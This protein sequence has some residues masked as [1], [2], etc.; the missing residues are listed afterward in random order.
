MSSTLCVVEKYDLIFLII[1][2]LGY[3]GMIEFR[4]KQVHA[5]KKTAFS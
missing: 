1:Q 2:F 3:K 4:P 5:K